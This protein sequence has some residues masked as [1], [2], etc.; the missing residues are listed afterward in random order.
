MAAP[1]NGPER[2][3]PAAAHYLRGWSVH[4]PHRL[5]GG[6]RADRAD[7]PAAQ[8]YGALSLAANAASEGTQTQVWPA[9]AHA[10][11]IAPGRD[12]SLAGGRRLCRWAATPVPGE[13]AQAS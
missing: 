13:A 9:G 6:A 4:Q 1:T 3:R 10:R 8:R 12:D 11:T 5:C 7:R 2:W